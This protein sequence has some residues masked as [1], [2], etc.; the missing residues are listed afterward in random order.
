MDLGSPYLSPGMEAL[1]GPISSDGGPQRTESSRSAEGLKRMKKLYDQRPG[2]EVKT[3]CNMKSR[4][5]KWD[6]IYGSGQW[7]VGTQEPGQMGPPGP[8]PV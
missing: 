1:R 2:P 8:R 7:H 6:G 3:K 4:K 5:A